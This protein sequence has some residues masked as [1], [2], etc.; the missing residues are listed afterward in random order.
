MKTIDMT[1]SALGTW[2]GRRP[3]FSMVAGSCS[4]ADAKC[5][6]TIRKENRA[7]GLTWEQ[8]CKEQLGISR[9][10]ADQIIRDFGRVRRGLF[11]DGP[12]DRHHG[13]AVSAPS[14]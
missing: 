9:S 2:V 7:L 10:T 8:L 12:G 13:G 14:A 1:K 5:L 4:A 11:P 6:Q 3:A